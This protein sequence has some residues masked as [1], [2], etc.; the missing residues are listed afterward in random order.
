MKLTIDIS[1]AQLA[2]LVRSNDDTNKSLGTQRTIEQFCSD[3]IAERFEQFIETWD[4]HDKAARISAIETGLRYLDPARVAELQAEV[5]AA[6]P[7][8][9]PEPAPEGGE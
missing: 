9:P 7:V 5:I 6:I 4:N 8:P 2:A 1:E 3:V